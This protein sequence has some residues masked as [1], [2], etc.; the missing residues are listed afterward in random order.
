MLTV[1]LF[2]LPSFLP[3]PRMALALRAD[4]VMDRAPFF[5]CAWDGHK[6]REVKDG[7]GVG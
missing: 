7:V 1:L 5:R 6:G 4:R 3:F 2:T